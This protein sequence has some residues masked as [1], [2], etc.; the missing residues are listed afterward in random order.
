MAFAAAS[1]T[2]EPRSF[3]IGPWKEQIMT[4]S[5]ASGDTSGTVTAD[6]LTEI[7]AIIVDGV[8]GVATAAPTFA[9]NV[10]TLA[11]VNPAATRYGTIRV[12]GR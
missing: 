1:L 6:S 10:A 8:C 12:I 2:A 9:G 3:S 7:V 11:F 5:V 4:Y